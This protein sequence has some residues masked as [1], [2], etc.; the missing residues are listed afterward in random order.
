MKKATSTRFILTDNEV[1]TLSDT[2]DLL[3]TMMN[4]LDKTEVEALNIVCGALAAI[5]EVWYSDF[6]DV[7]E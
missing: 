7:E 3:I 1:K 2:K 5:Q 4:E 6:I